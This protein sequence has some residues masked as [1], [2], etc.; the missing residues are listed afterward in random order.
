MPI[1]FRFRSDTIPNLSVHLHNWEM[2]QCVPAW[3]FFSQ[4][5]GDLRGFGLEALCDGA[6]RSIPCLGWVTR[7]A[8][9]C[10]HGHQGWWLHSGGRDTVGLY[11]LVFFFKSF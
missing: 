2:V 1:F 9:L 10:P 6:T 11:P 5:G 3:L 7:C 8:F 4:W